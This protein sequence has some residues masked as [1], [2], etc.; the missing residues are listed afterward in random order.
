MVGA[1]IFFQKGLTAVPCDYDLSVWSVKSDNSE[2][3]CISDCD[4]IRDCHDR[5]QN[6][7]R[8]H[9]SEKEEVFSG[10]GVIF[11]NPQKE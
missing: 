10:R 5:V 1:T 11:L 2:V 9:N 6:T 4:S 7:I 8:N 3:S